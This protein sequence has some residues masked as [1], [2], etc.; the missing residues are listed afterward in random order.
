MKLP[1]APGYVGPIGKA[2]VLRSVPLAA[3]ASALDPDHRPVR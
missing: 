1:V 2:V 3:G